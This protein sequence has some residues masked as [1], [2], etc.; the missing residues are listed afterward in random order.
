MAVCGSIISGTSR[1]TYSVKSVV[2]ACKSHVVIHHIYGNDGAIPNIAIHGY[3]AYDL[4]N[5]V[6][7]HNQVFMRKRR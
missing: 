4:I 6:P 1:N 2:L 5:R 3:L 7:Y